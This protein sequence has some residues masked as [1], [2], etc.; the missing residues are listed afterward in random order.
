MTVNPLAM[1]IRAKKLG[2][3]IRDARTSTGTSIEDCARALGI[4]ASQFESYERGENSP[5][6]PEM[7]ILAFTLNV[8]IE[9]F[10]ENST[11]PIR[12]SSDKKFN[13]EQLVNLR[14]RM[15][16]VQIRQS[17]TEAGLSLEQLAEKSGIPADRLKGYELGEQS[18][19][20]P[21]LETLALA[22]N[23]PVRDFQDRHGPVGLW[24]TQQR[25]MQGF[26]EMPPDLQAFVSKPV[27]QPFLELAQRLSE[28]SVEKLRSVAEGLLEIT[29]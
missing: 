5:S 6:L 23:R 12:Q 3:L 17:R 26:L 4:P 19:P 1:T 28:M 22:L 16:G 2:V 25:A 21:L 29:L 27:N 15:I 7:E 11:L 20:L 9:H 10:W 8:P 24:V 14:Q 18:I 13:P